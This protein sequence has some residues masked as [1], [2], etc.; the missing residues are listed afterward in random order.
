MLL[1]WMLVAILTTY[2]TVEYKLIKEFKTE[3]A[4]STYYFKKNLQSI[5]TP[6]ITF[7]CIKKDDEIFKIP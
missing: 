4:C 3:K 2:N 1:E 7:I 6:R 5:E